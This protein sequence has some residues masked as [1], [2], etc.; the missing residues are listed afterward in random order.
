MW[1]TSEANVQDFVTLAP[2]DNPGDIYTWSDSL[3]P[4]VQAGLGDYVLSITDVTTGD[5]E[6]ASGT[7]GVGDPLFTSSVVDDG[8]LTF[9]RIKSTAAP[10]PN[11]TGL[12][13]VGI[14]S[15]LVTRKLWA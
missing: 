11:T 4:D 10:E 5:T 8:T 15:L 1:D 9:P 2:N 3:A 13:L 6:T 7:V 14:G 12:I